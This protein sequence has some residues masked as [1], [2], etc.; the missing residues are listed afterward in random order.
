MIAF[1][2]LLMTL[3]VVS[4]AA[5]LTTTNMS[6]ND[7]IAFILNMVSFWLAVLALVSNGF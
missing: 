4:M 5:L 2:L 3:N 6:T 7:T 1:W